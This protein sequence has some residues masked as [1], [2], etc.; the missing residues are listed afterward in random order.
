MSK[1]IL[2]SKNKK[3]PVYRLSQEKFL[4]FEEFLKNKDGIRHSSYYFDWSA[5]INGSQK[6]EYESTI[7]TIERRTFLRKGDKRLVFEISWPNHKV[8]IPLYEC[9]LVTVNEN[10]LRQLK[11]WRKTSSRLYCYC[12]KGFSRFR[13]R[14]QAQNFETLDFYLNW[15]IVL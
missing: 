9:T 6:D 10:H 3:D 12:F 15:C 11:S 5:C 8:R 14:T 13:V 7:D 2:V 1:N 4:F